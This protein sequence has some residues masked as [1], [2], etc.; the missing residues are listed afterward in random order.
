MQQLTLLFVLMIWIMLLFSSKTSKVDLPEEY[1]AMRND[2]I[3][4]NYD[5]ITNILYIRFTGKHR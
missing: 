4:G 3:I 5:S 2:T 1:K